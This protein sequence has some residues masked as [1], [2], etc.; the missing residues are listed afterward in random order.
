MHRFAAACLFTVLTASAAGAQE[1][2]LESHTVRDRMA[3][4]QDAVTF[5]KPKGW[6]VSGGIQWYLDSAHQACLEIKVANPDGLEQVETLPWCYLTW[7]SH[8]MIKPGTNYLG[9]IVHPPVEDP[10]KVLRELVLPHVR[11]KQNWRFVSATELPEIAKMLAKDLSGAKVRAAK[12]R[13]EYEVNG[14]TV[15]EDFYLSIFV[16]SL[17][18]NGY[19]FYSWGPAWTPFALRAAKG[20]LDEATPMLLS[21]VNSAQI[22]PKWFGEYM[23]VCE[24]FQERMKSGIDNAKK[25]SDTITKNSAEISKM[26]SD[27]YAQRQASQDRLAQQFSDTIRGVQRWH[28]PQET[29]P[30]QLPGGYQYAWVSSS[31][32]YVLSNSANFNPNVGSNGTWTQL[33]QAK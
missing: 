31:G 28:S 17:P 32:T 27:A 10:A 25:L 9:T 29:Y 6:T 23:Y 12:V 13:I 30:V 2:V 21:I 15:E 33:K 1:L 26:Y 24:L 20:K 18:A 22:N 14:Q 7:Q 19:T 4:H 8:G 5:L 16:Y 11:G 3:V